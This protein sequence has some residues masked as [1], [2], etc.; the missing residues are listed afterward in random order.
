MCVYKLIVLFAIF[1]LLTV[2][3]LLVLYILTEEICL[4]EPDQTKS[5][6]LP[7]KKILRYLKPTVKSYKPSLSTE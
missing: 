7:D 4:W 6:C 5:S 3:T 2:I 1:I